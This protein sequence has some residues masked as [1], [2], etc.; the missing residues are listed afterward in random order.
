[1]ALSRGH[2]AC[3]SS[4][5][6]TLGLSALVLSLGCASSDPAADD[7]PPTEKDAGYEELSAGGF[8]DS[9]GEGGAGGEAGG[10]GT[11]GEGGEAGAANAGGQAG[12]PGG[13]GGAGPEPT[14]AGTG[15][16]G[17]S[18]PVNPN[19]ASVLVYSNN[20]ENM[21][22]DW[23]D[24][25]HVM[26]RDKRK[27][28]VFLVQQATNKKRHDELAA[29]MSNRLGEKYVGVVAQND[30]TD[31]RFQGEVIPKPT[32]TTGVIWRAARFDY[33]S[34]Q[35]WFPWGTKVD[36]AHTCDARASHSGYETIRVRLQDKWAGK[37]LVAASLRHWTWMDCSQK[38]MIEMI[39][40][41]ASGPNA[42]PPMPDVGLQIVGGDFNGKAFDASGDFRCWYRV[43]VAGLG[44][45]ACA[46]HANLGFGEPLYD[47]CNGVA[48]CVEGQSGIDFVFGRRAGGKPAA[49]GGF[50]IPTYDQGDA[51]D[52]AE[53]G[54]DHL[55]NTVASQGFSDVTS[56]YS[57][58]RARRAVF[59][60]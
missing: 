43:S 18:A 51:A 13:S 20:I 37:Q 17:G 48:S 22:F 33:V 35:T 44:G 49:T 2:T 3:W 46:G 40:G 50:D 45:T 42:H 24:L 57:E 15:A 60:Y 7:G 28:D 4:G 16:T 9:S 10:A 36:G 38:N 19:A 8:G 55:S 41:Q 39:D 31:H 14:D 54:S 25:V 12:E 59:F 1:M 21:L 11:T 53:T 58:H 27:V 34:H 6:R 32:V 56:N 23:K 26:A 29:Y 52:A 5:V 30:P 47:K